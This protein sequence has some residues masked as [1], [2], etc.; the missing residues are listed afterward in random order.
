[1]QAPV[2]LSA[3]EGAKFLGISERLFHLLRSEPTF[4]PAVILSRRCVRFRAADLEE[5]AKKLPELR[6]PQPLPSQLAR[7][8][9]AP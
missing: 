5:Y 4:P 8:H 3:Q 1:M 6:G 9:K 7:T 2:L